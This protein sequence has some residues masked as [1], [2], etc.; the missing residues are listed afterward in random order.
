M[1]ARSI[2]MF[3]GAA[4]VLAAV[5]GAALV[6]WNGRWSGTDAST[7]VPHGGEEEHASA[8]P[9]FTT[10]KLTLQ[11]RKNLGL[12]ARPVRLQSY[13]RTIQVPGVIVERPGR[14]DRE[15]TAPAEGV[16]AQIH[17][18]PGD[19]VRPGAALFTLRLISQY[20]QTAQADLFKAARET[21]LIAE[22]RRRLESA[23]R[24]GAVAEARLI[25]LDQEFRRQAAIIQ[26][27]RQDLLTRGLT[28]AQI[29]EVAR[30]RFVTSIDVAA[31]A[32]DL[33]GDA[34]TASAAAERASPGEPADEVDGDGPAYEVQDLAVALGQQVA[35]GQLLCTLS[36]HHALYIEGHAFK[37]EAPFL[38]RAAQNRWAVDV[39]FADDDGTHWPALNQTFQIRHLA[40]SIDPAGRTFNF[41]LLL[42]NQS[43]VYDRGGRT[44][45]VWRFRPGQRVRLHV[46]VEEFRDVIVLPAAGLVREGPEA[47]VFRQNGDLFER[48]PVHVLHE[49][50]RYVVIAPD[51]RVPP[52]V[53]LAQ[54]AA[55]SLNRVLKAQAAEGRPA[56]VHVHADGT[57]H[58]A[59]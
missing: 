44:F 54:T 3:I 32:G 31:P 18:F 26:A 42:R 34:Q 21:E 9:E 58:G 47:Y 16:V 2:S 57:I 24:S 41:Y 49:D 20:L 48:R 1:P 17:A 39:E 38:E 37:R 4:V 23:A 12:T 14:S 30:G 29:D 10:V 52:G 28:T 36:N 27:S 46:P 50:R 11:A 35:A 7:S 56:G 13:W 43:R 59:H 40:N 53:Y 5:V 25:E 6:A 15:V 19:T 22:Q 45:L 8:A 51:S 33:A 55:A